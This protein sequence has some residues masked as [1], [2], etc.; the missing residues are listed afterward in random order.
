MIKYSWFEIQGFKLKRKMIGFE[1]A[2]WPE[3]PSVFPKEDDC[4]ID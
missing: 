1:N 2:T 4:L 3:K